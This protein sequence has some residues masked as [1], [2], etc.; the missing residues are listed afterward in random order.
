MT[1]NATM[2]SDRELEDLLLDLES[3]RV[4]RKASAADRSQIRKTICA[5][6]ND[7][8]GH[9]RPGVIFVGVHDDGSCAKLEITDD[10]LT[11]LAQ[12]RLNGDILP[13][14]T[15]SVQKRTIRGCDMAVVM[16]SPSVSPPVRYQGR[17]WVRVG[18]SLSI[19]T[20]EDERRLAERRRT[21]DLPFD[22]RPCEGATLDD[23]DL[24][25][26][27]STYLPA[28]V[29]P[30]DLERNDRTVEQ[31]LTSLRFLS[32]EGRPTYGAILVLGK[33]PL[34]WVPGAYIQFVRF[35]GDRITDP[36]KDQKDLSG[37]LWEVLTRIDEL[38]EINI[39]TAT[40]IPATAR[41]IRQ[42]DYPIVAL[43]QF[44]RNAVMHRTYEVTHAPTKVYWFADRIEITNPG[45]LYG[46][47]NEQNFGRGA[48]DYRN[49]FLAEAMKV[50]GYVQRFG[51][52]IPLAQKEL[53]RNGNPP[54]EFHFEPEGVMV[55][56][57]R[58]E[59]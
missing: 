55:T 25:F 3:D 18:P 42:P 5:F 37:Q 19:A 17:V 27:Q 29:G 52:G 6:A 13:P 26:F 30:D 51:L 43:Q 38:L 35:D 7:L 48:T 16:V 24:D 21:L 15:M 40:Q 23:L 33:D 59:A 22:S 12:M 54:A 8:P 53:K 10:L 9:G 45:G 14:P 32:R 50:L 58:T 47:V 41:E 46:L 1:D 4:E 39:S 57:R 56:V 34:R 49:P 11:L 31:Q 28:A 36:I 44:V 2:L 20:R